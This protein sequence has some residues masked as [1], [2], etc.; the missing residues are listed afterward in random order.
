MLIYNIQEVV[1]KFLQYLINKT[2]EKEINLT[3]LSF[4]DEKTEKDITIINPLCSVKEI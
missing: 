3:L 2:S 1:E 4:K